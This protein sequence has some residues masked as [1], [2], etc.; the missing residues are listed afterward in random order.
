MADLLFQSTAFPAAQTMV[1]LSVI[2]M[3]FLLLGRL[4][5]TVLARYFEGGGP[6]CQLIE[7]LTPGRADDTIGCPNCSRRASSGAASAGP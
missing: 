6:P 1:W 2:V 7:H 3:G 5:Q 4:A